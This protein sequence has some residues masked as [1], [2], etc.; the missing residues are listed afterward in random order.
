MVVESLNKKI[1]P[2]LNDLQKKQVIQREPTKSADY[3]LEC[4]QKYDNLSLDDFPIW[5]LAKET[6]LGKN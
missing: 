1:M 2:T 4:I 6:I 5:S 3:M